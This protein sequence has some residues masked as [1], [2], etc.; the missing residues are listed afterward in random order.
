MRV[1]RRA[2][3][4]GARLCVRGLRAHLLRRVRAAR[5]RALPLLL[6]PAAPPQLNAP[7]RAYLPRA[8]PDTTNAPHSRP[9]CL[10]PRRACPGGKPLH[11]PRVRGAEKGAQKP[12]GECRRA[13]VACKVFRKIFRQKVGYPSGMMP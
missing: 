8:A 5:R 12:S 11:A 2:L 13:G 1:V 6:R 3:R 10:A 9:A 7:R 4:R